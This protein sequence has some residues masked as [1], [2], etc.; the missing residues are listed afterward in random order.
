MR[1]QVFALVGLYFF[2]KIPDTSL[3]L[4]NKVDYKIYYMHVGNSF[5]V[6]HPMILMNPSS[7]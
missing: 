3:V 6:C 5:L 1:D 2:D 7:S 4:L